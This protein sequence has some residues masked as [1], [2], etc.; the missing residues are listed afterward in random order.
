VSPG[1]SGQAQPGSTGRELPGSAEH[2]EALRETRAILAAV[3]SDRLA[4]LPRW[5]SP[6]PTSLGPGEHLL[7]GARA[8]R[9]AY[10]PTGDGSYRRSSGLFVATGPWGIA[11]TLAVAGAQVVTNSRRR[12]A[13]AAGSV[14]RWVVEEQGG[15]WVSQHGLYLLTPSGLTTFAWDSFVVADLLGPR[16]LSVSW[17]GPRGQRMIGF[18]CDWAEL[19]FALWAL[20]RHP[21]HPRLAAEGWLPEGWRER[22]TARLEAGEGAPRDAGPRLGEPP[23]VTG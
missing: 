11:A 21:E 3:S 13:A 7:A 5:G 8:H 22:E 9:L 2:D 18:E 23:P 17:A 10:R 4:G 6:F 15:L 19:A 14:P 1:P 20:A 16:S 12:A